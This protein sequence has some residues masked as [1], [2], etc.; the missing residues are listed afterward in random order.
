MKLYRT[1]IRPVVTYA[2]ETWTLNISD[3]N[4]LWIFERK[5]IRKIYST[6]YEGGVWRVRSNSE[7]NSLLQGEDTVRHAIS[8]RLSWLG[9]VE[10]TESERTPKCLLNGELFGVRRKG[11]PRKRWLQD[12]KDDRRR[13]RI[14]K[15]KEKAQ[16][17]NTWRLIVKTPEPTKGCR[18][19]KE[20]EYFMNKY[21]ALLMDRSF[22][23]L[24]CSWTKTQLSVNGTLLSWTQLSLI[25]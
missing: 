23:K 1:L 2:A 5:V 22:L 11:R 6:V 7:I 10:H 4:A 24:N 14:G 21:V 15:W 12:V 18:A 19:E 25:F 8:L 17:Q 9:H 3:E 20:E 13:M 16:E